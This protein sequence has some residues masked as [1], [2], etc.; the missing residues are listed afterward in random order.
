LVP[1]LKARDPVVINFALRWFGLAVF[2]LSTS[3]AIGTG[4][5][6]Y[7]SSDDGGGWVFIGFTVLFVLVWSY[8]IVRGANSTTQ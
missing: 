3:L 7:S 5:L 8:Q 1:G 4:M 6:A 2:A